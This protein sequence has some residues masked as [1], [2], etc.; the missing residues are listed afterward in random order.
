MLND[1]HAP[2]HG[3]EQEVPAQMS[4]KGKGSASLKKNKK[5]KFHPQCASF[6]TAGTDYRVVHISLI[7]AVG[8]AEVVCVDGSAFH[9][10]CVQ[11]SC[12][13]GKK[14]KECIQIHRVLLLMKTRAD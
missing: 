12:N 13:Q 4:G 5:E 1:T 7:I 2:E 10:K 14:Q 3:K 6:L 11:L 8:V 9:R